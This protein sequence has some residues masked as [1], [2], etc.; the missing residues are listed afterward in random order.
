MLAQERH[1]DSTQILSDAPSIHWSYQAMRKPKARL[2]GEQP[3]LSRKT[4]RRE[5]LLPWLAKVSTIHRPA[6]AFSTSG[7]EHPHQLAMRVQIQNHWLSP[8]SSAYLPEGTSGEQAKI[9]Y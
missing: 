2:A 4:L 7:D 6:A 3:K 1:H 8:Q 5:T 9:E